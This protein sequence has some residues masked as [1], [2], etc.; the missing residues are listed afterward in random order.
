MRIFINFTM[1]PM[2]VH[3]IKRRTISEFESRY[4]SSRISFNL[5]LL[6]LKETDWNMAEDILQTYSSADLLGNGSD[7]VV[8]NIGGNR[9]RMIC[10]YV[11]GKKQVHLFICWIGTHA[12][13]NKLCKLN[14]Q[15]SINE[16]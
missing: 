13:Y 4:A 6:T 1:Y 9:F 12:D 15:Y 11:F 7:R 5:W 2:K 10:Q 14:K 16:F 3:L 8:F